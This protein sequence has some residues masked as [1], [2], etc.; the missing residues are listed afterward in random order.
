MQ[1][2]KRVLQFTL[3]EKFFQ[4]AVMTIGSAIFA[5]S[6]VLFLVPH[7]IAPGGVS[8]LGVIIHSVSNI[9][10]GVAMICFNVPI[11]VLG[12]WLLGVDF[13][14]KSIYATI[15]I[16]IFTDFFNE[17]FHLSVKLGDPI[18]AP[19]F[20][21]IG[22]GLGMGLVIKVGGGTSGSGTLARILARYINLKEGNAII[23]VNTGVIVIAGFVFRSADLALYGFIALYISALVSNSVIEG[24][25][26][27]K[28]AYIISDKT[29][30]IGEAILS[31]MNR[32][33]TA[34]HGRGLFTHEEKDILFIVV[35]SKEI[36]DLTK[37]ARNIDEGAFV[38]VTPVHEVLGKGFRRRI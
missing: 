2:K 27:V 25:D 34:L 37:I 16:A 23:L 3:K 9:P 29:Q 36:H 18:L 31:E 11:F 4:Y 28:G 20:G 32:G 17:F 10:V 6:L 8:G 22:L 38:I 30:E 21:G 1:I 13:S 26:Y 33:G 15:L 14:T 19:I 35:E 5:A 12:L 7:Q 24:M